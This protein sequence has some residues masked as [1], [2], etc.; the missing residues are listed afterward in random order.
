MNVRHCRTCKFCRRYTLS[1]SEGFIAY[2]C[3]LILER[4]KTGDAAI[5]PYDDAC[6]DY[7]RR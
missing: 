7:T 4:K 5:H 6:K 3:A 1:G 2:R